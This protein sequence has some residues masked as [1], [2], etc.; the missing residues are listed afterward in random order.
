MEQR[1]R[2]RHASPGVLTTV[3]A[4]GAV[5][6][7]YAV[8][9]KIVLCGWFLMK[10]GK[11]CKATCRYTSA[12]RG[13]P[14]TSVLADCNIVLFTDP[15]QTRGSSTSHC[16][17]HSVGRRDGLPKGLDVGEVSIVTGSRSLWYGLV[18]D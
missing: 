4:G 6:P 12:L 3:S 13:P 7:I 10:F 9:T 5:L 1:V 2:L 8:R 14:R 16:R 17:G 15:R 18:T 11:F